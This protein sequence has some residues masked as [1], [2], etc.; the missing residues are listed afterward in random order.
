MAAAARA[1]LRAEEGHDRDPPRWTGAHGPRPAAALRR[2]AAVFVRD[3]WRHRP[4]RRSPH[5]SAA[6]PLAAPGV[7]RRLMM[8][9]ALAVGSVGNAAKSPSALWLAPPRSA[10]ASA[11]RS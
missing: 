2:R 4:D 6:R 1:R 7:L 8:N 3:L 5:H 10:R 11:I 9:R